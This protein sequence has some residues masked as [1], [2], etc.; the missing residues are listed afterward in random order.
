MIEHASRRTHVYSTLL[1][2]NCVTT[3]QY[4]HKQR[5]H[6]QV[7]IATQEKILGAYLKEAQPDRD[8]GSDISWMN[9]H[10]G[11]MREKMRAI[12]EKKI[13]ELTREIDSRKQGGTKRQ[14]IDT[15]NV[16]N[17][18]NALLTTAQLQVLSRGLNFVSIPKNIN[19]VE[20]IANTEQAL[21][22]VPQLIKQLAISEIS[23]FAENWK[24][25]K[26][27]RDN[28]TREERN[29]LKEL[30]N[31]RD[32]MIVQADKGGKIVVMDREEYVVKVEEKLNDDKIYEITK[33]PTSIIK[34][35]ISSLAERLFKSNRIS[36]RVK[37]ELTSIDDLPSVRG[38]PK[39]HKI[40]NP[41]RIVTCSRNTITSPVSRFA[42]SLIQQ[43][44]ET[45]NSA[46]CN[47]TKFVEEISNVNIGKDD[48][49]VSL[50]VEDLFS[51]IPVTRAVDIAINRIGA[52]EQFCQSNMTKTDMKQILLV[53]LNNSYVEFNGKFYRQKQGLP[54]G[55]TLSPLLADLYMD[56]YL[57]ST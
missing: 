49:L 54:M 27:T 28:L 33:N 38:Q 36:Q 51:N 9:K 6:L 4:Q 48:R 34:K 18:S 53:A 11:K 45:I 14:C 1:N 56:E 37:Y 2:I 39:L 31:N 50:D 21:S 44:R 29:A 15:S 25:K 35:K 46:V 32:I 57:Q 5:K 24:K 12:H 19:I 10:D 17:K 47:T 30:K 41:M 40:N 20:V 7:E 55:N 16:V 8:H 26:N 22:N 3:L 42:F 13:I 43:L 23:T 52:S